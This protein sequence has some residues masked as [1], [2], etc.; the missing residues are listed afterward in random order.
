[1]TIRDLPRRILKRYKAAIRHR[2][3]RTSERQMFLVYTFL[4]G[5]IIFTC[6]INLLSL[7]G[8]TL[9]FIRYLISALILTN[10]VAAALYYF[11]KMGLEAAFATLILSSF[12]ETAIEMIVMSFDVSSY[13]MMLIM[14]NVSLL[15]IAS[16]LPIVAYA[17]RLPYIVGM[18]SM[19]TYIA[20]TLI[21]GSTT[22]L[23]FMVIFVFIFAFI[24]IFGEMIVHNYLESE[25]ENSS[26]KH[27][28]EAM[29]SFFRMN[30]DEMTGFIKLSKD[31]GLD[32]YQTEQLIEAL[33]PETKERLMNTLNY[34]NIEKQSEDYLIKAALPE[35][36]ES[37]LKICRL[38]YQGKKLGEMSEILG[39]S[40]SN[41]TCQ[42]AN[43]RA[44]LGLA[45]EDSLKEA[46][47][48]RVDK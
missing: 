1:M 10:C 16:T 44:K 4:W 42:R 45:K 6:I 33:S 8:P 37:E 35:L 46:I 47:E 9:P 38:I 22:L 15:V 39:K 40:A 41:I 34:Y 5:I 48:K 31:K 25:R 17:K 18:L 24:S 23:N 26:L 20:C 3:S 7:S 12:T 2:T 30:R 14:G 32:M 19:L 43:I 28:E 11:R 21:T 29:L 13:G 36:T 27:N